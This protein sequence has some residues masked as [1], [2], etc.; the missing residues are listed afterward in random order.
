MEADTSCPYMSSRGR[1]PLGS[2]SFFSQAESVLVVE[3][4]LITLFCLLADFSA[5]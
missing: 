4:P 2:V 5:P 3:L 1:L